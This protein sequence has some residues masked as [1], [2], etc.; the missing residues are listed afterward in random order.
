MF[1]KFGLR[2][3]VEHGN[4][5]NIRIVFYTSIIAALFLGYLIGTW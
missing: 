4:V 5:E 1:E 3:E 2:Y